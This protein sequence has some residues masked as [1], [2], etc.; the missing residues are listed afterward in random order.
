M[1]RVGLVDVAIIIFSIK[2]VVAPGVCNVMCL[3]S[4]TAV[5]AL[6]SQISY[7]SVCN[8]M[9]LRSL[10]AVVAQDLAFTRADVYDCPVNAR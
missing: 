7:H 1:P 5:V 6:A 10:A 9:G 2:A 4:R 3:R 8:V